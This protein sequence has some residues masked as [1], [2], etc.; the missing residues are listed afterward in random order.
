[1]VRGGQRLVSPLSREKGKFP[2]DEAELYKRHNP[3]SFGV[4]KHFTLPFDGGS[5][6]KRFALFLLVSEVCVTFELR[7]VLSIRF[8]RLEKWIQ[9]LDRE[10]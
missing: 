5:F 6:T 7:K 2:F 3:P 8:Y 10:S 4:S 1:M 9:L